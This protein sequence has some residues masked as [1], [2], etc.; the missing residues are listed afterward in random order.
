MRQLLFIW[1]LAITSSL[2]AN[3]LRDG[4]QNPPQQARPRVWWHWMNG[5]IT[6]DGLNKDIEWMNRVGIGG[7]HCFDAAFWGKSIVEKRLTYMSPEWQDHFRF[8]VSMADSLGMEV[9]IASCP[10]VERDAG[11]GR[12][13]GAYRPAHAQQG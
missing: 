5:N 1:L 8:A 13:A 4:F 11:Q 12:Q 9:A 2:M 3:D 10:G 7:I 6:R